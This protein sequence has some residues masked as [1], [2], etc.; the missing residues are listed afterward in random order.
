MSKSVAAIISGEDY[1]ARAG[2]L[3]TA[4]VAVTAEIFIS[5]W[6]REL[7]RAFDEQT[8]VNTMLSLG[9]DRRRANRK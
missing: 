4:E 3:F 9:K 1:T 5:P 8:G 7:P 2:H 6:S